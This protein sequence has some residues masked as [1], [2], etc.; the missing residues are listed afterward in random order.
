MKTIRI[1]STY[2]NWFKRQLFDNLEQSYGCRFIFSNNGGACDYCF[3]IDELPETIHVTCPPEN[4]ILGVG[5]PKSVKIYPRS[6]YR[7]FGRVASFYPFRDFAGTGIRIP[8]LPW[9]ADVRYN[10]SK[11]KWDTEH[12]LDFKTLERSLSNTRKDK[13]AIVTS[14]KC[15]TRGHRKRLRF[16]MRIKEILGQS[17]DIYGQGFTSIVDKL[18]VLSE[19]KYS[20]VIENSQFMN[21]WTEKLADALICENYPIYAG[22]PNILEYFNDG[23]LTPVDLNKPEQAAETIQNLIYTNAY[24]K[25]LENILKAKQRV[26]YHYNALTLIADFVRSDSLNATH[27]PIIRLSVNPIKRTKLELLESF[28]KLNLYQHL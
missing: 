26:L 4:L 19:Y 13:I 17:I 27:S 28:I 6:Y 16:V 21:Y 1:V 24:D 10:S 2:S 18:S 9:M 20:L 11:K 14:N 23:E 5:E 7:Q 22:C 15:M 8:L 3:V 25:R 12:L